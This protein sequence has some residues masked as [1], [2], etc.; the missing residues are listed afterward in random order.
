MWHEEILNNVD[1]Y[2][3][4]SR[5]TRSMIQ[6]I[7]FSSVDE[8]YTESE[9]WLDMQKLRDEIESD[10]EKVIERIDKLIEQMKHS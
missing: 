3:E 5:K 4:L 6:S 1:Q 8:A 10:P 9:K 7:D 2:L